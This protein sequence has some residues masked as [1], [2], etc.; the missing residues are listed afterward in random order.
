MEKDRFLEIKTFCKN[1]AFENF[2]IRNFKIRDSLKCLYASR[3]FKIKFLIL[4]K[5]RALIAAY[6]EYSETFLNRF[7][8][9]KA[10]Y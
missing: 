5:F 4:G 9:V 2:A 1:E 8:F 6:C 3:N 10:M 7:Q